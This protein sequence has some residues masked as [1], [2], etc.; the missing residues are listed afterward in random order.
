MKL[1]IDTI[2]PV[3]IGSGETLN[4]F[5]Y[6]L[7]INL[8][9]KKG[10]INRINFLNFI[11]QLPREEKKNLLK[12][13]YSDPQRVIMFYDDLFNKYPEAVKKSKLWACGLSQGFVNAIKN[14]SIKKI[15]T[16]HLFFQEIKT[17]IRASENL[18]KIIP[19]SSIKGAIMTAIWH[20]LLERNEIEF[21]RLDYKSEN[22]YFRKNK[23]KVDSKNKSNVDSL[24]RLIKISDSILED[25]VLKSYIF[26]AKRINKKDLRGGKFR[27]PIEAI[28]DSS[29]YHFVSFVKLPIKIDTGFKIFDS[30]EVEINEKFIVEVCNRFYKDEILNNLSYL[31]GVSE[32]KFFEKTINDALKKIQENPN[33][34]LLL[35]GWG[36]GKE[37]ITLNRRKTKTQWVIDELGN[38][39][40]LGWCTAE[41]ITEK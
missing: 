10:S 16:S 13:D 25:S 41:F 11:S 36:I 12:L 5:D 18:L 20:F 3:Y 14:K 39:F 1:K 33:K 27:Q 24:G 6:F 37:A 40:P 38:Y 26:I 35:L 30:G 28:F 7:K 15:D 8:S 34:F 31:R 9:E 21:K 2:T 29:S 22:F 19:G 32:G 17:F 4:R 23:S